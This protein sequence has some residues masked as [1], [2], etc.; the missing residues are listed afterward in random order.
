MLLKSFLL[1]SSFALTSLAASTPGSITAKYDEFTTDATGLY[2]PPPDPYLDLEYANWAIVS[3]SQTASVGGL[4]AQSG[5]NYIIHSALNARGAQGS[6]SVA[7]PFKT[8]TFSGF[9][10]GCVVNDENGIADVP[11]RCTITAKAYTKAGAQVATYSIT[12]TPPGVGVTTNPV[13][14]APVTLPASFKGANIFRV[15]ITSDQPTLQAV[16]IDNLGYAVSK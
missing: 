11:T 12:F 4:K 15:N 7:A 5:N 14:L 2:G 1:A 6:F 16:F 10:F 9:Y 3:R 13:P 8:A